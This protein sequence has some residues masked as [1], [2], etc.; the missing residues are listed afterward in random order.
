MKVLHACNQ[1]V[2]ERTKDGVNIKIRRDRDGC[3]LLSIGR[4]RCLEFLSRWC[5][6]TGEFSSSWILH[7]EFG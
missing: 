2:A 3:S 4:A 6:G 5:V 1:V 7:W